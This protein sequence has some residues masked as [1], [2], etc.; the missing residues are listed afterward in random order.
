MQGI[1]LNYSGTAVI[2]TMLLVQGVVVLAAI[3]PA[4]IAGQDR[5][6]EQRDGLEG[7]RA[8]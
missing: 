5:L 8:G 3:V 7:A 1:T 2:K 4:I 6:A